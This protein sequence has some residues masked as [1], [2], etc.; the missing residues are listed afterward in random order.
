[1]TDQL[2]IDLAER[3]IAAHG[4]T[5]TLFRAPG[6]VNLI[7]E[8]T[9]Y[10]DG[11]VLPAALDLATFIAIAP[12]T[13]RRLCVRS[14]AFAET[15][16]IDLDAPAPQPRGDWTDYVVGVALEFEKSGLRLVGANAMI[17]GDLAMG[18]G[19]SASAALEV[20]CGFALARLSGISIDGTG[21][22]R[23][24]QR[25]ENNFVGMR[26]GLM[27]QLASCHGVDGCALLVDCRTFERRPIAIDPDARLVVCDTMVRHRL[28][29]SEYNLRRQDCEMAVSILSTALPHVTALRDVTRAQ[30]AAQERNLP[31]TVFRRA[32][33]VIDENDRTLRAA[34]AL[35]GGD[36][37][38]CG[39][40]MN[41]SH[42]SLRD[43]YEVSCREIDLLVDL[44]RRLSG[45]YGARMTGGGFGGC[46]INLV[47][48]DNADA[49]AMSM[50]DAY[51][52]AIGVVPTIFCCRPG[53][54][55]GPVPL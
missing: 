16:A 43:D 13:D 21:L 36:L 6:R 10:N 11:F 50:R 28:A 22:A 40:L 2:A 19:L 38:E 53:P 45:V 1:M 32:R 54:G 41:A 34:A 8:H 20:S 44:A 37:T 46:T 23:L 15:V 30:L 3:F 18:A 29:G 26:C 42:D 33:H 55:V 35:E 17:D 9:D 48:R 14:S 27:D 31:P 52:K 51:E 5:P 4:V 7:G 25:A 12:R 39:R 47:A 24:C 49:F